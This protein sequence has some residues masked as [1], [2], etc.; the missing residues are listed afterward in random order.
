ML[1]WWIIEV[2]KY[3]L[4][5]SI[6]GYILS[7]WHK[8]SIAPRIILPCGSVPLLVFYSVV[9]FVQLHSVIMYKV[10]K[11]PSCLILVGSGWNCMVYGCISLAMRWCLIWFNLESWLICVMLYRLGSSAPSVLFFNKIPWFFANTCARNHGVII[12]GNFNIHVNILMILLRTNSRTFIIFLVW[13]NGLSVK[14]IEVVIHWPWLLPKP[15]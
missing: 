7:F 8:P 15:N 3:H 10:V 6:T 12:M 5:L 13:L 11:R 14:R 1:D 4:Q 2:A 9:C